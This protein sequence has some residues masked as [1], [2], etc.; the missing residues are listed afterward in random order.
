MARRARGR[1]R[2]SGLLFNRLHRTAA[3]MK[4]GGAWNDVVLTSRLRLARNLRRYVFPARADTAELRAV[5]AEAFAAIHQSRALKN[6]DCLNLEDLTAIEQENLVE[7]YVTS[8]QHIEREVGRGIAFDRGGAFSILV[9]E[10]DHLRLQALLPGLQLSRALRWINQADDALGALCA[11]AFSERYGYLTACPTNVGTGLRASVMLHLLGLA[12]L[13]RL[14]EVMDRAEAS[15]LTV[16]GMYGEGS[17]PWG[18]LYQLSNQT[19]LGQSEEEIIQNVAQA[20]EAI[21][22]QELSAREELLREHRTLLEDKVWRAYG[23]LTQARLISCREATDLLSFVRLGVDTGLLS[24]VTK[25][26]LNELLVWIRPASLQM[27]HGRDLDA[28]ER[29]AVRARMIRD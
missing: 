21:A 3:W 16:R 20:A 13:K 9:N 8:P 19:T 26:Q 15:D 10:E 4:G 24:G 17:D 27:L 29:D 23:V 1:G 7:R 2:P 12:L 11:F 14:N 22:Q 28:G 18:H 6:L 25:Q 5:R